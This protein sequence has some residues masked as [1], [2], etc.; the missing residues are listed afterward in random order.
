MASLFDPLVDAYDAARPGYPDDLYDAVER[1]A[2]PLAGADVVE[3]GAGT[4]IATRALQARG[5]RV[6]VVDPGPVML[7]RLRARGP[8]TPAAVGVAEAVP[9]AD[10]CA[11]L[12]CAAQAWH[13]V[14]VARGAAEV[15]RLLRPGGALALWWNDVDTGAAPWWAT[16][17][18]RIEAGNPGYRRL[19]RTADHG[20]AL[21][22][23]GLF[24]AVEAIETRWVRPLDL[25]TY[26]TWLRSKSY[27][28]ALGDLLPDFLA[29]E[30]ASL[31]EA[32]PDGT[33][34]EP[35]VTRLWVATPSGQAVAAPTG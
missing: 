14:D 6:T 9:L 29:A 22:A 26:E 34:R 16:Q 2:G 11:D 8:G 4:G 7:G 27:V 25:D 15:V 23:T 1:L 19:Y 31:L 12:V 20:A 5:A 18:D 28:A 33:V 3:L 21:A 17:Q 13:W 10:G 35:F 30:R 32:F 24:A